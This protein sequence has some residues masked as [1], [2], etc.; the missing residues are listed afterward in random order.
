MIFEWTTARMFGV[1]TRTVEFF[2]DFTARELPGVGCYSMI[3]DVA[4]MN[5]NIL[6]ELTFGG[7]EGIT[8]SDINIFV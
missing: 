7:I 8:Q 3:F 1:F 6:F 5:P 4:T 2:E